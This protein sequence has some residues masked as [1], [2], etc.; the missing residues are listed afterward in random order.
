MRVD[1]VIL[2]RLRGALPELAGAFSEL[3][4]KSQPLRKETEA[5]EGGQHEAVHP[6][7]HLPFVGTDIFLQLADG[8]LLLRTVT[9][10]GVLPDLAP[11]D[12]HGHPGAAERDQVVIDIAVG[13]RTFGKLKLF[14]GIDNEISRSP[15]VAQH[16]FSP[17]KHCRVLCVGLDVSGRN[18]VNLAQFRPARMGELLE[19]RM[20]PLC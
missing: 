16:I 20:E 13:V 15:H 1:L 18:A 14:G 7:L 11:L 5:V 3:N 17:V 10:L 6:V 8:D 12:Q 19:K 4:E 2:H 9:V